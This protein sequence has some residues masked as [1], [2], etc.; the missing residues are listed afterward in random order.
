MRLEDAIQTELTE[1]II[2]DNTYQMRVMVEAESQY[3]KPVDFRLNMIHI[4]LRSEDIEIIYDTEECNS[5]IYKN[6]IATRTYYPP[7]STFELLDTTKL[8]VLSY[9]PIKYFNGCDHVTVYCKLAAE[10]ATVIETISNQQTLDKIMSEMNKILLSNE[11]LKNLLPQYSYNWMLYNETRVEDELLSVAH[12]ILDRIYEFED[13]ENRYKQAYFKNV[14]DSKY[15]SV[16]QE[17]IN[18]M[19]KFA[20]DY[21]RTTY[22]LRYDRIEKDFR[23]KS[24]VNW[25]LYVTCNQFHIVDYDKIR[26]LNICE[27]PIRIEITSTDNENAGKNIKY[28]FRMPEDSLYDYEITLTGVTEHLSYLSY[29][30]DIIDIQYIDKSTTSKTKIIFNNEQDDNF[31]LFVRVIELLCGDN[32]ELNLIKYYNDL[33]ISIEKIDSNYHIPK[34]SE[35]SK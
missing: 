20:S 5:N 16:P 31:N 14:L 10:D 24:I 23:M 13:E 17:T 6:D 4:P 27:S 35:D 7:G 26:L 1:P 2:L 22:T 25:L 12:R 15:I 8:I 19:Y 32:K 33:P 21:I 18:D 9:G 29:N 34:I 30:I 11:E 28:I 3:F